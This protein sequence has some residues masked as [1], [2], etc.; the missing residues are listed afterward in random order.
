MLR[1]MK[2]ST[3]YLLFLLPLLMLLII[4][5]SEEEEPAPTPNPNPNTID[6]SIT[7]ETIP[8]SD[9]AYNGD[10]GLSI[11]SKGSIYV[12]NLA[13]GVGT[14]I[15]K[16]MPNGNSALFASN[17]AGPMGHFFDSA[18]NLFVAF[19]KSN[20]IARIAPDGSST[21]YITDARFQGGSLVVDTDGTIYHS[22]FPSNSVYKISPDKEITRMASGGSLSVPFGITLDNDKNIYV[23]NFSNGIISKITPEG[24]TSELA[25]IPSKVGYLIFSGGK[26]YATGFTSHNI[27]VINL[28]GTFSVLAGTSKSG[29]NDGA[30]SEIS[31]AS[32]NGIA[33]SKDGKFLYVSQKNLKIRKI[34]LK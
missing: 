5:C 1:H 25:T 30:G 16:V 14:Q 28:D 34:K 33:A 3:K 29:N 19:N 7:A 31:F 18:D 11:D 13:S 12:S 21:D 26:L 22:V 2:P 8:I 23:A 20:I 6:Q 10:D 4:N 24:N 27:Y 32:P 17:L 15:H 9:S